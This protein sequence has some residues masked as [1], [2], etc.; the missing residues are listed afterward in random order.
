MIG[1]SVQLQKQETVTDTSTYNFLV[2]M[3]VC[4]YVRMCAHMH[5]CIYV[6]T[7]GW[8]ENVYRKE[9]DNICNARHSSKNDIN[10]Y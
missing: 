10:I 6:C 2:C 1:S 7:Y 5:V 4:V 9:N 3:Y 8:M